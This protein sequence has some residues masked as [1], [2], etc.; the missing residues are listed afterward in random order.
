VQVYE[1]GEHHGR[2]F[3]SMEYVAGG[4]LAQ[5]LAGTPLPPRHAA[6]LVESLA[7]AVHHAHE[8]GVIHRDLKPENI[9]LQIEDREEHVK[10][11]DFGIATVRETMA[12]GTPENTR[13]AGTI[14][15]MSPE[16]LKGRPVKASDIYALGVIVYELI[17]GRQ[18]YDT[19]SAVQLYERQKSNDLIEPCELRSDLPAALQ[20]VILKALSFNP[21]DRYA[22]A[23]EFSDAFNHALARPDQPDPF[24]TSPMITALPLH[25]MTP[26]RR[27]PTIAVLMA[28]LAA[29]ALGII[30]WRRL[31]PGGI[32]AP[33]QLSSFPPIVAERILTYQP[34]I[35]KKASGS[36]TFVPTGDTIVEQG[37]SF[38]LNVSSPQDGYLYVINQTPSQTYIV[39]FPDK[40]ANTGSAEVKTGA[41]IQIP[42]VK[43]G[44]IEFDSEKG[45]EKIWLIW[46]KNKLQE[47]EAVKQWMN[48][49]DHGEIK[50]QKQVEALKQYLGAPKPKEEK[51][52]QTKQTRLK[53][54]G[55]LLVGLL[56]IDHR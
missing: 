9:M 34:Q 2:P 54:N 39:W 32:N 41:P 49:K 8:Q 18:P 44:W 53:I 23:R 31:S 7:R 42:P 15:Y 3:F 43:E 25:T 16:Q 33:E 47:L 14:R 37:D 29:T 24:Q 11:I 52:H 35:K 26:R 27:L 38:R 40:T 46:S 4:N 1:V 55:D 30:I 10:L 19:D 20:A 5:R 50:N 22:G 12:K 45:A 17:T 48:S 13:V 56:L 36:Q 51:D 28:L 21:S 6:E